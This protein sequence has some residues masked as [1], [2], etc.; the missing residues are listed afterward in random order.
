MGMKGLAEKRV[1]KQTVCTPTPRNI[2]RQDFVD[3]KVF[4]LVNEFLPRRKQIDWDIEVIATVRDALF[5]AVSEKIGG[6]NER[7]FYP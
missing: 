2:A 6:L 4:E 7:R 1:P 5:S 3:N